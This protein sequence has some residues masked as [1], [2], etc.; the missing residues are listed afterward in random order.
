M[1]LKW[2]SG[3]TYGKLI[4]NIPRLF[5]MTRYFIITNPLHFSNTFKPIN[6]FTRL[7][8]TLILYFN[9]NF[10]IILLIPSLMT[11]MKVYKKEFSF[12]M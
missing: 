9:F 7:S 8:K 5:F 2:K 10:G 3:K 6:V 11:S 12:F 4:K 1:I